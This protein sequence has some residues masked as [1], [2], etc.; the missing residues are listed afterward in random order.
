M[1]ASLAAMAGVLAL[2]TAP[3]SAVVN[4]EYS[5]VYEETFM[6]A[7]EEGASTASCRCVMDR[8]EQKISFVAFAEE[9]DRHGTKIMTADSLAPVIESA[10]R[11]CASTAMK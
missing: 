11:F 7:C 8:V 4:L 6:T 3:A 10:Q 2:M 5:F 9:V 1:R